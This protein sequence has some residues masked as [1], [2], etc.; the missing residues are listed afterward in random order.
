MTRMKAIDAEDSVWLKAAYEQFLSDDASNDAEYDRYL[1]LSLLAPP[2]FPP[3]TT[4]K[5][6]DGKFRQ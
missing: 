4:V 1:S 2:V 6:G 3:P 5:C